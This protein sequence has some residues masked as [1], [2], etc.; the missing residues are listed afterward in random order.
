[1]KKLLI[2]IIIFIPIMVS[3]EDITKNSTILVNGQKYSKIIDS[4]ENSFAKISI[5]NAITIT[6]EN[7]IYGLYVIYHLKSG[8]GKI[9]INNTN[10]DIGNNGFL[11]EYID[12]SKNVSTN[13]QIQ[14][15]EDTNIA[16]IYVLSDGALPDFVETWSKP[17]DLA[18]IL[19]FSTHSDDEHLF[20]AGLI[21]Y[22][23]AKDAN[24]QVVYFTNHNDNPKRLHEQLHG[25]YAVGLRNYPIIGFIPDKWASTLDQAINNMSKAGYSEDDAIKFE[26]EMI[27]RFKPLVIVGHDENG[28]YA[29]G[30]H[31]LNTY[32][33][34]KAVELANDEN[35][36]LNDNLEIW[37]TPKTY[38]H[39]YK[40]NKITM[41]YDEPLDYFKGKTAYE[42][43]KE[44]Y[45]K[46]Y[47]QQYTWFTKWLT[48]VNS[49]GNGTKYSKATDI[50][51]YSPL[52]F[53][54]YR[55]TV[56]DDINKNEMLENVTLRKDEI[57]E[58]KNDNKVNNIEA[59]KIEK[60]FNK[61][62]KYNYHIVIGLGLLFLLIKSLFNKN[63]KAH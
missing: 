29:H 8:M 13:L 15:N 23:V 41:N 19:L 30:Q 14:Y 49:S 40:D 46:H 53:G 52:E 27:R 18:D 24:V 38:L 55:T 4:N 10:I 22:Y 9:E 25:L 43:S 2:L 45:S 6:N 50:K 44:G 37:N 51:T 56:G 11:H 58:E 34:K 32:V 57:H 16:E 47:S 33:L 59:E 7:N 35:Y 48:G 3:A 5:D 54:L 62:E 12:L 60:A 61:F 39:L 17:H 28:E 63:K 31:M 21:P 20:F 42:M 36:K 1:M 26:V